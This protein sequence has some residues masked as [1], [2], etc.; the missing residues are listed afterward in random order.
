MSRMQEEST[1]VE[2]QQEIIENW[3]KTHGHTLVGFAVDVNVSGS[4]DPFETAQF[5][6]WLNERADEF[7]ITAAWKLDRFSRRSIPMNKLF[8][9]CEEN[10]KTLVA[11]SDNIDLTHWVGRLIAQVIA[12]VAEGELEAIKERNRS[13]HAKLRELGR[14]A[15][16][17]Y[18]YGLV[19]VERQD[20]A[21]WELVQDPVASVVLLEIIDKLLNNTPLDTI[22]RQLTEAGVLNPTDHRRKLAGK[23]TTGGRWHR[24]SI[25]KMLQSKTL[26]G[27][28]TYDGSTV[29]DAEGIPIKRGPELISFEKYQEIQAKLESRTVKKQR[30]TKASPLLHVVLCLDC[31]KPLYFRRIT[32]D[33]KNYSYYWCE[34]RHGQGIEAEVLQNLLEEEFLSQLGDEYMPEKVFIPGEDHSAELN[35]SVSALDELT[36]MLGTL[37]SETAKKRVREQISALDARIAELE[38]LPVSESRYELRPT[39]KTFR[40]VWE[41]SDEQERR[42]LLLKYEITAKA[43]LTDRVRNAGA[44]N[45]RFELSVPENLKQRVALEATP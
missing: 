17:H 4:T 27:Y 1:S 41:F 2:R 13:S 23:K 24:Q 43:K 12:G 29:F 11:I 35:E 25:T 26:L 20:S 9:W 14:W 32:T 38:L 16:G 18:P 36:P 5:G 42:A 30:V 7:E 6:H 3:A 37:G 40:Q 8:G 21:G 31:G 22:A 44:G 15:G 45:L 33:A 28:M 19:P 34:D 10:K 39:N